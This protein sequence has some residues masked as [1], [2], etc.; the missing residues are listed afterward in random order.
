VRHHL[1]GLTKT[2]YMSGVQCHKL[3]WLRRHEP[4]AKELQPDKVLQDL[5]DQGNLVGAMAR[6]CFPGGVLIPHETSRAERARLTREVIAAGATIIFEGSFLVDD[7]FVACDVLIRESAGWRLIEVKSSSKQKD[8]HVTDLAVQAYV[9]SRSGVLVARAEVMHLNPDFRHPDHGDLFART[10]V[11]AAVIDRIGDVP[12]ESARQLAMLEGPEPAVAI[13]LQCSDPWSC[14]F[15]DRCWPND[16]QHISLLYN[17]GPKKAAAYMARG[18]HRISELPKDA[19]LPFAA[20]RQCRALASGQL[21]VEKTLRDALAPFEELPLGFLDFE[22]VS[23]AVPVWQAMAP[24]GMAAAQFSY[25][26]SLPGGDHRHVEHLAEGPQDARPLVAERLVEATRNAAKVVAYS[27]FEK[28]RIRAL[29]TE[30]P[31]LAPE[32]AALEAKLVD[33][34]PILRDH[35]YHP[36]FRGSFSLKYV[37]P[38]MVPD[39]SYDDLVIVDGRLASVEIARLLFV[40]DRIPAAERDRVRSDLLAYCKRDTWAMVRLLDELRRLCAS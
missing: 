33:L 16:E 39:L 18:I 30:V 1:A 17:V 36:A 32:L 22:T 20:R 11:T 38:A 29:I 2:D 31:A 5:F 35:V 6:D 26:E 27:P 34:H 37:L 7:I 8:E 21:I 10:D 28:T 19:K 25:H 24:W 3:L 15:H 23:R 12:D 40:A 14:A 9:L 4:D 13:G